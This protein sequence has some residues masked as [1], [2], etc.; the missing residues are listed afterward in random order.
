MEQ[1]N[2]ID[3]E[4]AQRIRRERRAAAVKSRRVKVR[5]EHKMAERSRK[6]FIAGKRLLYLIFVVLCIII[7]VIAVSHISALQS[8][9]ADANNAL[10]QKMDQQVRLESELSVIAN[11][12]YIEEQARERLRMIKKGETLYVFDADKE[13]NSR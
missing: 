3:I 12:E 6:S 2:V 10:Q 7:A 1:A 5:N 8:E 9:K 4:E 13:D 11:P